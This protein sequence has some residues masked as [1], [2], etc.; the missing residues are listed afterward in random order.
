MRGDGLADLVE[1]LQAL[2]LVVQLSV[3]SSKHNLVF[4]EYRMLSQLLGES[5]SGVH[6]VEHPE[7]VPKLVAQLRR[8]ERELLLRGQG[9]QEPVHVLVVDEVAVL[10]G[11]EELVQVEGVL[12]RLAVDVAAASQLAGDDVAHLVGEHVEARQVGVGVRGL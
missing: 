5:L 3:A 4:A 9:V 8:G 2:V 11:G 1:R 10:V 12:H 7:R 6:S